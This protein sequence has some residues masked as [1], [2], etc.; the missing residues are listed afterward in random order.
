[1]KILIIGAKGML[2]QALR[3]AEGDKQVIAWDREEIDITNEVEVREKIKALKPEVIINCAAYNAVDKAE[4]EVDVANKLNG[5]AVGYLAKISKELGAILVQY[6]TGYVFR[7]DKP[8]YREDD[9]PNPIN[10]YGRSKLLGEKRLQENCEKY[11]L[12]RT[13]LLFGRPAAGINGKKSFIEI[14]LQ[15]SGETDKIE[16]VNDEF[17]NPTY[18][19]DLARA[20]YELV[21]KKHPFGIYHLINDG[22]A[23]WY[24]W[25]KEIFAIKNIKINLIPISGEKLKRQA[26]RPK[27]SVLANTKF[28]KLRSW[29]EAV[30]E[31]LIASPNQEAGEESPNPL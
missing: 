6:S 9:E 11:Y 18:V 30:R 1:M 7:G 26:Q 21:E 23:S 24:D 29:P 3:Q 19:V 16:V 12:I 20:T 14:M 4:G 5:E 22:Q 17:S 13:N 31:Y 25:A 8:S 28:L 10:A 27:Y 2:G 15:K